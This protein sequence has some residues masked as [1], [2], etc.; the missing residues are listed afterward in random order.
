MRF[1]IK[2]I[3]EQCSLARLCIAKH[4]REIMFLVHEIYTQTGVEAYTPTS[5]S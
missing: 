2:C 1:Q 5:Y 4:Y 3:A